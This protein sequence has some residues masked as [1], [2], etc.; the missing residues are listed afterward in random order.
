MA[1]GFIS[2]D[3]TL[4]EKTIAPNVIQHNLSGRQGLVGYQELIHARIIKKVEIVRCLETEDYMISHSRVD[5]DICFD[6]YRWNND[7]IA[8]HWDNCQTEVVT[9]NNPHTMVDGPTEACC[10]NETAQNVAIIERFQREVFIGGSSQGLLNYYQ[11]NGDYIQHNQYLNLPDGAASLAS[12]V[13]ELESRG[14]SLYQSTKFVI[15]HGNFVLTAALGLDNL[16]DALSPPMTAYFDLYRLSDG[17]IVEH[18]DT[19][20]RIPDLDQWA[21]TNGKW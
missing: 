19:V 2:G 17:F 7:L 20:S 15:G 16:F 12:L 10:L 18:W 6:V 13:V 14:L 5:G 11:P 21:N 9:D 3:S 4:A 8:E 1:A